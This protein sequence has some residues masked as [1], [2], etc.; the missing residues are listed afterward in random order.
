MNDSVKHFVCVKKDFF[1]GG[2]Y[3]NELNDQYNSK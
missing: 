1:A 3:M 2:E